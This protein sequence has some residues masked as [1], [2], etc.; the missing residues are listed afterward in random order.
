MPMITST[1]SAWPLPSTPAMPTISPAWI[2][3]EMS[4]STLRLSSA[5]CED[6]VLD[7]QDDAVGDG[8]LLGLRGRQLGADHELGELPRRDRLRVDSS[9]T[10][11]PRRMTV[12]ASASDRTSS[13][14]WEMKM[15]VVPSVLSS[16]RESKSSSTSC[17]TRTAVGSSRIRILAPR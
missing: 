11:V 17:G 12:M 10:V 16:R 3:S 9:S 5:P 14:L 7:A 1:S 6:E 2:V 15:T 13:S 4:S 8:G